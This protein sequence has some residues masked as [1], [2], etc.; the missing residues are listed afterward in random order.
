MV[1]NK[2][3]VTGESIS[4]LVCNSPRLAEDFNSPEYVRSKFI[5][6][7]DNV[8][9]HVSFLAQD[10]MGELDTKSFPKTQI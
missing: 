5:L 2:T 9:V 6:H 1:P 10:T 7:C 8:S 4:H 3:P